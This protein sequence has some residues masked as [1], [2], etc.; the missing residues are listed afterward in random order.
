MY[1]DDSSAKCRIVSDQT[2]LEVQEHAHYLVLFSKN[3]SFFFP[4]IIRYAD[5]FEM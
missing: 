4:L 3:N 2:L 5:H 1:I